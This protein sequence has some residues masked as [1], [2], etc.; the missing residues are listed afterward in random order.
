M[1]HE[2]DPRYTGK[3]T[4]EGLYIYKC[5]CGKE[6]HLQH[7]DEMI[8]TAPPPAKIPEDDPEWVK[9]QEKIKQKKQESDYHKRRYE[10]IK[11][12]KWTGTMPAEDLEQV[13]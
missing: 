9:Q 2:H 8:T 3:Q 6:F 13:A 11:A 5:N 12:G 4:P 1:K 7:G 10:L